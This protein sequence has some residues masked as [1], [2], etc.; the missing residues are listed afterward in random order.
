MA[1]FSTAVVHISSLQ[2]KSTETNLVN[3]CDVMHC[4]WQLSKHDIIIIV[5]HKAGLAQRA[6]VL[7]SLM[8]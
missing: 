5:R 3:M 2:L 4:Q 6:V 1:A 8:K 7:K